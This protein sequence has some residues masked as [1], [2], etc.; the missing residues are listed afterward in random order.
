[1]TDDEVRQ[2]LLSAI[3]SFGLVNLLSVWVHR[4]TGDHYK[5]VSFCMIER[6]LTPAVVYRNLT[7][8][9]TWCRPIS[10]FIDGRFVREEGV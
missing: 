1:M 4:K 10:E 3:E 5:V 7:N 2:K 9:L 8:N 6:D